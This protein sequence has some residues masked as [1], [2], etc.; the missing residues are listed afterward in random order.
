MKGIYTFDKEIRC[1]ERKH[2]NYNYFE[3]AKGLLKC[4]EFASD[5]D[6]KTL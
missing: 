1:L 6:I 3:R 4:I 2:I 5:F